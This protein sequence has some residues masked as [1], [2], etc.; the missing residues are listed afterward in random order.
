[1]LRPSALEKRIILEVDLPAELPIIFANPRHFSLLWNNL[2]GNAV[3]YTPPDGRVKVAASS[4]G[5]DLR[6][7]VVDTGIGI[8]RQDQDRIFQEFYRGENARQF[9]PHGTGIGL[10]IV[11]RVVAMYGGSI[12]LESVVGEGSTFHVRLP[13]DSLAASVP[14]P[15]SGAPDPRPE[16]PQTLV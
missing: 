1:M 9:A 2:L 11:H 13:L 6:V 4:D 15:P 5:E 3:K 8:A 12:S 14:Q 10:A 16:L 7:D